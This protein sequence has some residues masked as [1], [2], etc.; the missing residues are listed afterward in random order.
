MHTVVRHP[1]LQHR[2]AIL[3]ATKTAPKRGISPFADIIAP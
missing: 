3:R 2:L 1:L